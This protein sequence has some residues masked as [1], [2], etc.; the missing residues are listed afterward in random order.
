MPHILLRFFPVLLAAMV[1]ARAGETAAP[2]LSQT[3]QRATL[4]VPFTFE[5]LL[6]LPPGYEADATRR[7]PLVLFLHG[8]GE[9]GSNLELVKTHGLPKLIGKGRTFPFIVISPQCPDET[10]WEIPALEALID[11]VAG[12]LRVDARR[13]YLTGLSMGGYA[14][15]ALIQH[16]PERYAAAVPICGGG[17]PRLAARLRDLPLWVF[18]GAKDETVPIVE[19]AKMVAAIKAAGGSPRFTI[20][21][22]AAHDSWTETYLNSELYTW[23][24]AQQRPAR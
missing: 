13:I 4:S 15:W 12:R 21:P 17:D 16:R 10:R 1:A 9:R 6:Y 11:D 24:L 19:S 22:E 5:Y 7:W 18:H 14:T 8:I 20:Y 23:L 2:M 3:A